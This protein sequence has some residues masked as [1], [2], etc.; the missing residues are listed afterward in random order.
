MMKLMI[1]ISV[2]A[3][4][5]AGAAASSFTPKTQTNAILPVAH[6]SMVISNR[7]PIPSCE[8]G[9]ECI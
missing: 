9:S 7:M 2:V 4:V 6:N 1:R 8:P 5:F 3:L